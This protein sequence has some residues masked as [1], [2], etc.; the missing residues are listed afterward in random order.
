[1]N[2][3]GIRIIVTIYS[4]K[5][6]IYVS[7][8]VCAKSVGNDNNIINHRWLSSLSCRLPQSVCLSFC[9]SLNHSPS[10]L[11]L[12]MYISSLSINYTFSHPLS[13]YPFLFPPLYFP[14]SL[15]ISLFLSVTHTNALRRT[16]HV[17]R[18]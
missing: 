12:S 1:M 7:C 17:S 15:S 16:A 2:I 3:K 6:L 13:I 9:S 8:G 10:L 4:I 5:I 18:I 14:I 11:P